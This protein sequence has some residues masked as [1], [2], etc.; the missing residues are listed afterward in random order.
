MA[1]Y[2]GKEV[3]KDAVIL[4]ELEATQYIWNVVSDWENQS[5]V[6]ALQY[7][8]FVLGGINAVCGIMIN[9]YYRQKLKLGT[10]GYI[11]SVVPITAMPALLTSLFHRHLVTTDMLLMKKESCPICYELRSGAIQVG[12]GFAY[13]MVL[14]PLAALMY[15]NRYNTARIPELTENPRIMFNFLRKITRPYTGTL[16]FMVLGQVAASSILTYFEMKNNFKLRGK[17]MEI[18]A[19]LIANEGNNDS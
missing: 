11:A 7:A 18:E 10:Y 4:D 3:P 19:K 15:A 13:P 6:W 9:R 12:M 5:D 17:I 14:G 1:L 8:P 2:K 16:T